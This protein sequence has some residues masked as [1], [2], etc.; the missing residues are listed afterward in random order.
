MTV[1][2]AG[3]TMLIK[4]HDQTWPGQTQGHLGNLLDAFELRNSQAQGHC[5]T[6]CG[7]LNL[8]MSATT[9]TLCS[10][11]HNTGWGESGSHYQ[12]VS[13]VAVQRREVHTFVCASRQCPAA[14][15]VCA[16][17]QAFR[18]AGCDMV[19]QAVFTD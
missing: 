13:F 9:L 10:F 1:S 14:A 7:A 15:C 17:A 2:T 6:A 18:Q 3:N 19:V 12:E 5:C 16:R 8:Q 4:D 11:L